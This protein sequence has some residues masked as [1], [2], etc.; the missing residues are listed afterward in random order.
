MAASERVILHACPE[1]AI[2]HG[3]QS[4]DKVGILYIQGFQ[5]S[6][7]AQ[8]REFSQSGTVL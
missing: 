7:C 3:L 1:R 4:M 5:R 8:W 2:F 6:G